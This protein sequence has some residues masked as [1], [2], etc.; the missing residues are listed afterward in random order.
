MSG[1]V[2]TIVSIITVGIAGLI[3]FGAISYLHRVEKT[4][5]LLLIPDNQLNLIRWTIGLHGLS[6]FILILFSSILI[7]GKI[8]NSWPEIHKK[9]GKTTIFLSIIIL[10]PTGYILSFLNTSGEKASVLFT[11]LTTLCLITLVNGWRKIRSGDQMSHHI[12]MKRYYILLTSAIWLR[13]NMFIAFVFFT[14]NQDIYFY[15]A[16]LSWVPQLIVYEF[17]EGHFRI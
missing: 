9:I 5:Y 15:C 11:I 3:L 4:G 7:F 8:E 10:I 17:W 6:A 2:K 13:I 14:P 1:L 12:W 16:L